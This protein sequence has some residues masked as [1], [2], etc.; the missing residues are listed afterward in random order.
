MR[1]SKL[2]LSRI[3]WKL[4]YEKLGKKDGAENERIWNGLS[5]RPNI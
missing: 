3:L 4:F 1:Y 5:E 2:N